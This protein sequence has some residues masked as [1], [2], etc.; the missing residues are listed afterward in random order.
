LDSNAALG[1]PQDEDEDEDEE[2]GDES[3]DASISL[4][5]CFCLL[6]MTALHRILNS[7]WSSPIALLISG[8][9]LSLVPVLRT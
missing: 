7:S 9:F 8:E 3:D 2:A 1:E 6:T 5:P 4:T